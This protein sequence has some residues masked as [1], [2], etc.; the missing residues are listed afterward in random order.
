MMQRRLNP[1]RYGKPVSLEHFVGRMDARN[2]IVSRLHQAESTAIVG[3]P[4]IGKSSVLR[5]L[6]DEFAKGMPDLPGRWTCLALNCHRLPRDYHP[7]NLWEEVLNQLEQAFPD[8]SLQNHLT[9]IR[10][11]QYSAERLQR[12]FE[13]LSPYCGIVLVIDEFDMLLHHPNFNNPDFFGALRSLCITCDSLVLITASRLSI[14]QMNRRSYEINPVSSPYF[15]FMIEV[16]L[17]AFQP[18]DVDLLLGRTLIGAPI[19]FSQEDRAYIRRVAG[20]HPYLV[21]IAAG[22]LFDVIAAGVV[23]AERYLRASE[24]FYQQ[25]A[26]HFDELWRYLDAHAQT[27]LVILALSEMK[28]HADGRR[29]DTSDLGRLQFYNPELKKL[30]DWGLVE[31]VEDNGWHADWDASVVWHGERWRV[32]IGSLVCWVVD[33]AIAGSRPVLDFSQW[34]KEREAEF[35][36]KKGQRQKIEEWTGKISKSLINGAAESMGL[37]LKNWILQAK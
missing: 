21:Q 30:A 32:S 5:C 6:V 31:K 18:A 22:T 36:W 3:A 19:E 2:T 27:A 24:V 33:T 34:L 16:R 10:Q 13:A 4:Q 25:S 28:G 20:H 11:S 35:L 8:A 15:N 17:G 23:G 37:L 14:A 26:A 7:K 1:F 9:N 12:L 29:F